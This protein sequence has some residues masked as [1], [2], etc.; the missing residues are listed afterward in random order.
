MGKYLTKLDIKIFSN[1]R[2]KIFRT[3]SL[4]R[5]T[6]TEIYFKM[7]VLALK[8]ST[9]CSSMKRQQAFSYRSKH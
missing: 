8:N 2:H 1:L 9:L 5:Q 6:M 3:V 4:N 7:Y